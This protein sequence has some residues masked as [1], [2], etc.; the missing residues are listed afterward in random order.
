MPDYILEPINTDF[1]DIYQEFVDYIQNFFP[2][3][4]DDEAQLDSIMGRFFSLKLATTADM[5][6][7]VMRGIFVYFG[8]TLV[9]IQPIAAVSAQVST[10]WNSLDT[11]GPYDIPE[12]TVG[13]L[14]DEF[15]EVHLFAT[16]SDATIANGVST[17]SGVIMTALEEGTQANNLS[18]TLIPVT[19]LDWFDSA[20]TEAPSSSGADAEGEEDYLNR[21]ATNFTLM[22]PRP[23]LAE[24]FAKISRNVAGVWRA[25]ALDNFIPP[26]NFTA[27]NAVGV[28]AIDSEGAAISSAKKTELDTYLQSL[29]QQNFIVSVIDPTFTTVNVTATVVKYQNSDSYDVSARAAAAVSSFIDPKQWGVPVWPPDSRGWER[30]TVVRA[31]EF[32]T[33]LNNVEGVE[34]VSALSFQLEG[35]ANDANDKTL[36][37]TFPLPLPG[38]IT[39]TVT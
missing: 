36:F 16:D 32:Y 6:S 2:D 31:Q 23:I 29:R 30:K 8:A 18:G 21:L 3:W 25:I 26:S 27:E 35:G 28:A 9:N 19:A 17:V 34:Y 39:V 33:A 10:T 37:G 38:V 12:G 13:A 15:G 14:E 5:A 11:D 7:R 22:A 4:E 24:D 20:T 1:E